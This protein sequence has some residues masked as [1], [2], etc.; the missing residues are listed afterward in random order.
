LLILPLLMFG[1]NKKD[2]KIIVPADTVNILNKLVSEFYDKGFSI[3]RRD[4][5]VKFVETTEK[6]IGHYCSLK[7]R[8]Q[9]K[10]S[11]IVFTGLIAV[12]YNL[13]GPPSA[14]TFDPLYYGGMKGSDMRKS[15]ELMEEVAK[16]F[17]RLT[18]GK[19]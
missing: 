14:R 19:N 3:E 15:W 1:Q 11:V 13:F 5:Q 4:D 6:N 12:N 17:G 7:L 9:V 2:T 10:D 16:K 18:Y 8:A